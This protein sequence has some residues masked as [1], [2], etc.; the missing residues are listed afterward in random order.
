MI[1]LLDE[2]HTR[3]IKELWT[4]LDRDFGVRRLS[5]ILPYPHYS[6]QVARQYDEQ[7]LVACIEDLA[8]RTAPFRVTAGGLALFTGAHP[9]LYIP[10][11]RTLALSQFQQTVCD[12]ISS[13]G[14]GISPFYTPETWV[15]HITLAEHDL[16]RESLARIVAR[17]YERELF[18]EIAIDNLAIIWDS[19][20]A[21]EVR[22]R[23][24]FRE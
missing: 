4:E 19:G 20:T 7:Q 9:V 1:S 10:V 22:Y 6:Y 18:W 5:I 13:A 12:T 2:E 14:V 15:P 16:Q 17:L 8:R 3:A 24:D 23:F 11:L 21:Q